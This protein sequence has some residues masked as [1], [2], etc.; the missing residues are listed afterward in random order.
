MVNKNNNRITITLRKSLLKQIKRQARLDDTSLSNWIQHVII[1]YMGNKY[2][3]VKTMNERDE[4]QL[5]RIIE[6]AKTPW[7]EDD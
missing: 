1:I 7:L 4:E 2:K 3:Y 6:I 5:S